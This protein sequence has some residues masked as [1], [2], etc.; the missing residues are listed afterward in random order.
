MT[1]TARRNSVSDHEEGDAALSD[2]N[3]LGD[4]LHC[5]AVLP[6]HSLYAGT[7]DTG[8]VAMS[9]T[10]WPGADVRQERLQL[11][12][13]DTAAAEQFGD[14]CFQISH[15]GNHDHRHGL[16]SSYRLACFQSPNAEEGVN[17]LQHA[18]VGVGEY[19]SPHPSTA[20]YARRALTV[21][22]SSYVIPIHKQEYTTSCR[23][24]PCRLP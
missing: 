11:R 10:A 14:K 5:E 3:S 7:S 17:L 1:I 21:K 22:E 4:L 13:F 20:V 6:V 24:A 19:Q 8:D 16:M 18:E 9:R 2:T 15:T 23:G 12:G